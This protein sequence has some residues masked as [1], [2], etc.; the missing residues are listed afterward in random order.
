MVSFFQERGGEA[1]TR[2][3]AI[4]VEGIERVREIQEEVE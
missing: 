3:V 1:S 2:A 4:S